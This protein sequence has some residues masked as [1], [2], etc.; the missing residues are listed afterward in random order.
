MTSGVCHTHEFFCTL[1]FMDETKMDWDD[2]RLFLAVARHGGL[3]G[4]A[5]ETG[6]SAP[7]LGRRM[8]ALERAAGLEL[9]RRLPRGYELTEHGQDFL[10]RVTD[11]EAQIRPLADPPEGR[12][13]VLVKISAG[14]WMTKVLCGQAGKILGDDATA[15]LRFISADHVLDITH[16]EAVIGIRNRRP[17]QIGLACRKVGRVRFAGY[18]RDEAERPWARVLGKTPSALW[19]AENTEGAACLEVTNPRGALDLALAGAVRAVLPTFIGD[20]EAALQ[21]VTAPIKE[22]DHDQWL[23]THHEERFAPAVRQTIDRVYRI[24]RALHRGPGGG[25]GCSPKASRRTP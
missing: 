18:A 23:V 1:H 25:P 10:A 21:R 12:R 4:A 24:L 8:L 13:R 11:L 2:L 20:R 22:L 9:F 14:T 3:A 6:K 5:G 7:T 15:A 16:R 17:E 19:V